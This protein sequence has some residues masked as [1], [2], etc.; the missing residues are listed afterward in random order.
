[1][2]FERGGKEPKARQKA[3]ASW[4]QFRHF[5]LELLCSRRTCSPPL[6]SLDQEQFVSR[7]ITRST[8]PTML[9]G[10][11]LEIRTGTVRV[12]TWLFTLKKGEE[13][14]GNGKWWGEEFKRYIGKK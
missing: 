13:N 9:Q 2:L 4:L 1:M 6:C 7:D 12:Q 11:A 8:V 5:P 10:A 3:L 14:P